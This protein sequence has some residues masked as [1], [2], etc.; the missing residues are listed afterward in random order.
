MYMYIYIEREM[1]IYIY[2]SISVYIYIYIHTYIH[3]ISSRV[4]I[5]GRDP[6]LG[7]LARRPGVLQEDG[8][9]H[10]EAGQRGMI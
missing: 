1:Y 6:G 10:T 9:R 4:A 5:R 7:R 8:A 3:V 2:I